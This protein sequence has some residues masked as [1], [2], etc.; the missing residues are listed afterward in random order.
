MGI[1]TTLVKSDDDLDILHETSDKMLY[2]S[3]RNGR[4]RYSIENLYDKFYIQYN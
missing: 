3:K 2:K 1:A 4:N